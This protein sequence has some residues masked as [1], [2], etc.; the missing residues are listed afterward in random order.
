MRLSRERLLDEAGATGFRAEIL[1]KTVQLVSLLE[2]LSAYPALRGRWAL[3]GGTALNLFC[4]NLPRLSVDADI[5]YVGAA[6]REEAMADR[7]HVERAM[8]AVYEREGFAV[9]RMPAE[10]AGGKWRLRFGAATGGDAN[11]EVDLNFLLRVPMWPVESRDSV[12]VGSFS[13]ARI[14]VLER[15]ELAAGKLAALLSRRASRDLFDSHILLTRMPGEPLDRERLRLAFVVYGGLNRKDWRTVSSSD[16]DFTQEE[17]QDQL[18]PVL[19]TVDARGVARDPEWASRLVEETRAALSIVLP[20]SGGEMEF[21]TR[22][23]DDGE[24][25]PDILTNDSEMQERIRANPGL[26]WKALNVR[27]HRGA[28]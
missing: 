3:K 19:S 28:G 18:V 20:L 15:H 5:N 1:E 22:L 12:P 4:F 11:L 9:R 23:L 13:A 6:S 17:L 27:R 16:I 24:I 7:P 14:P 21:L 8:Q 26:Q 25:A 2:A 10:H